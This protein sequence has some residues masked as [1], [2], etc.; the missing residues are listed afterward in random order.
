MKKRKQDE[1]HLWA[2]LKGNE[3][4]IKEL[5]EDQNRIRRALNSEMIRKERM[6]GNIFLPMSRNIP[7]ILVTKRK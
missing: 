4:Q 7:A 5:L 1:A 6:R 3:A 2:E